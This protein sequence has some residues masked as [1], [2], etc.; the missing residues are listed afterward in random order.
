MDAKL[1]VDV[2]VALIALA[3][4]IITVFGWHYAPQQQRK[5]MAL[6]KNG[7]LFAQINGP[8]KR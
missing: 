7:P 3:A 4:I 6:I 2:I 5:T 8:L 1:V